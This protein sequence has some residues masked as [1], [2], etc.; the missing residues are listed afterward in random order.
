[1]YGPRVND[2]AFSSL[3]LNILIE[4]NRFSRRVSTIMEYHCRRTKYTARG[5]LQL[6]YPST[7]NVYVP[8]EGL[9]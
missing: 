3:H 7:D 2:S 4:L 5:A 1:M 6:H 9:W 8:I